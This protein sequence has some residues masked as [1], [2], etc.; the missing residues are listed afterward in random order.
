MVISSPRSRRSF[1][2]AIAGVGATGLGVALGGCGVLPAVAPTV[3]PL[4]PT[5]LTIW[6]WVDDALA[7]VVQEFEQSQPGIKVKIE[8]LPYDQAHTRF[9]AALQSGQGAP[10]VFMTDVAWLGQVRSQAGLA[11]L[12][13][14]P[15]DGARLKDDFLPWMWELATHE[16]RLVAL[17][18]SVGV[19]V[20]WYRADV[21]E[22]AGL[23]TDPQAVGEQAAT[24]DGW[25]AL[26]KALRRK[27]L[28][29]A[30]VAESLRLFQPAVAQ[31][32]LGWVRGGQLLVEQ[33]GVPAAELLAQFHGRDVPAELA[34]GAFA[35]GVIDGSYS[36]MVAGSWMQLFL[37][38]DF[39]QTAGL[40]RIARAPGG[41]FAA[42]A[43]F[44]CIPQQ[45][46][47]QEA[48]WT[49]VKA[50]CASALQ[51]TIFK[52]SGALPAYTGAWSDPVYDRPV[53]FFG[54][55]SAYRLL[56]EAAAQIPAGT[57]SRFD[58]PIDEIVYAEARRVAANGKDPAEAMAAA[59]ATVRRR[60]PEVA[61]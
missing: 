8:S 41:D 19:G 26:D 3:A 27:S 21:L 32:G 11:D 44:L 54:G 61:G 17:P 58:R 51:N 35:R 9:I 39:K 4:A 34:G 38:R 14:A 1:F 33:K 48:A 18:W 56:A 16:G 37:L 40:W 52:A 5:T 7:A 29:S 59:A 20:A 30:L 60:I 46:R 6:N 36:G 42:G 13:A 23:P 25:T 53:E 24:W 28:K 10:D 43:D 22:A 45:S 2:R 55:Q 57:P 49:F 12:G 50:L 15:F 47:N 31:Q